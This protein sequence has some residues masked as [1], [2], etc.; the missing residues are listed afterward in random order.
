MHYIGVYNLKI[1]ILYEIGFNKNMT[2]M[3]YPL[4]NPKIIFTVVKIYFNIFK[5]IN[6]FSV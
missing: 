1:N 3:Y 2:E 5:N 6:I 4:I